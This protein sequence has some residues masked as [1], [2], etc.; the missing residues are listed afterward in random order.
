M[1][2]RIQYLQILNQANA[3]VALAKQGY[4]YYETFSVNDHIDIQLEVEFL[5]KSIATKANKGE[6]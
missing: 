2:K 4:H 3:I 6:G 5:G 1:L